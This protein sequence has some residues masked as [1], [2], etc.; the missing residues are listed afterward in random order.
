MRYFSFYE[1]TVLR[2]YHQNSRWNSG[3]QFAQLNGA[4]NIFM[5]GIRH[6]TSRDVGAHLPTTVSQRSRTFPMAN[7]VCF[8]LLITID[9]DV[10]KR[11]TKNHSVFKR[12]R[13]NMRQVAKVNRTL[14]HIQFKIW[15]KGSWLAW[16]VS[17]RLR[18]Q[19]RIELHRSI[20]SRWNGQI[21]R[22]I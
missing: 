19:H 18:A 20:S 14:S 7:N 1:W 6:L 3:S 5:I 10:P 12:N 8:H 15:T 9:S 4:W 21:W 17:T 11:S 16:F 2:N 22:T 13:I